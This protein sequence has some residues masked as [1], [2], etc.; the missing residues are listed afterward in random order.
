[1]CQEIPGITRSFSCVRCSFSGEIIDGTEPAFFYKGEKKIIS[2]R[3]HECL[4]KIDYIV[5][6]K[7]LSEYK[8]LKRIKTSKY[9]KIYFT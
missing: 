6:F 1:M 5:P 7:N 8:Q 3:S 9:Q 4:Q 2:K